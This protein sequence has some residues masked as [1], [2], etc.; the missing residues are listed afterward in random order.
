MDDQNN[1]TPEDRHKKRNDLQREI[2]MLESDLKKVINE[3]MTVDNEE[4]KIGKDIDRMRMD[5]ENL[6]KKAHLLTQD[7]GVREEQIRH[8][9]KKINLV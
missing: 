3:K 8:L 5:L 9:K 6:Q 2:I 4:R 7:I 1:Q